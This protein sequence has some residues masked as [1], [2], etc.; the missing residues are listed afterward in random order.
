MLNKMKKGMSVLLTLALVLSQMT[1]VTAAA[2]D[3]ENHWANANIEKWMDLGIIKGYPSGAFKPEA[4]I[5]RAEFVTVIN[6]IFQLEEKTDVT[7][8]DVKT[9]DWF[10][11][12]V[13]KASTAGIVS[14]HNNRFRPDD[15]ITRQEAAIVLTNAFQLT[16]TEAAA[17]STYT[18]ASDVATWAATQMS[19]LVEKGYMQGRSNNELAPMSN[20]TRAEAVTLLSNI[21]G[22]LITEPGEVTGMTYEGNLVVSSTGVILKDTTIKGNLYIAQGVADGEVDLDNVIVEGELVAFGG[23]ENTI[24]L[25]NTEV[26]TLRVIKHNGKIRILAIGNTKVDKVDMHSG[27][28]LQ[29]DGSLTGNGFGNV[30]IYTVRPGETL[31]LEGD[32]EAL[33][34]NTPVKNLVVSEGSVGTLTIMKNAEGSELNISSTGNVGNLVLSG[35]TTVTGTGTITKAVVNVNGSTMTMTPTETTVSKD[36]EVEVGG[37]TVTEDDNTAT[38]PPSGGG[39]GGGGSTTPTTTLTF[40]MSI[41]TQDKV[42]TISAAT[43][44]NYTEIL[45]QVLNASYNEFDTTYDAYIANVDAGSG[46]FLLDSLAIFLYAD[47]ADL[48]GT[49]YA[50]M[51]LSGDG[52][53]SDAEK[54]EALREALEITKNNYN[55]L[56]KVQADL[57]TIAE[58]VDFTTILYDGQQYKSVVVTK[59]A[60]EVASYIQGG[61]KAGY[62]EDLFNELEAL[63][64]SSNVSYTVTTTLADDTVRTATFGAN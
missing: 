61:D 15:R 48:S 57:T 39:G 36:V 9:T 54:K 6:N 56:A 2:S 43:N 42:V 50:G 24:T 64:M 31:T 47:Q 17:Y 62:I 59:G 12:A 27:G 28:K 3:Y 5:T 44:A 52:I 34:V 11:D 53:W 55:N 32:F 51:A 22:E 18:D 1:M 41:G 26:G 13:L 49:D 4:S 63:T 33:T 45:R 19:V 40:E 25:T 35:S 38:T 60:T 8:S 46:A 14:G 30:E 7:F 16:G 37:E 29:E 23:G 20:L 10:E 58:R 21:A